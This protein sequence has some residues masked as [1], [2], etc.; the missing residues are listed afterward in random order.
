MLI[1]PT[2]VVT[3]TIQLAD[4]T[5]PLIFCVAVILTVPDAAPVTV[6]TLP[7][8]LIVTRLPVGTIPVGP[9]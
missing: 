6:S 1:S 4:L 8:C 7:S 9:A 2:G 5:T 3:Y